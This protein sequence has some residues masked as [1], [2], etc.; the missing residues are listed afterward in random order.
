MQACNPLQQDII[1]M[2]TAFKFRIVEISIPQ[3]ATFE[4]DF[5]SNV[6]DV[7]FETNY[8]Y[9]IK[10]EDRLFIAILSISF[11][12]EKRIVVKIEVNVTFEL[13]KDTFDS[14]MYAD[15]FCMSAQQ[16]KILTSILYGS[17]RGVLAAKLENSSLKNIIL[18]LVDLDDVMTHPLEIFLA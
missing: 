13:D 4:S 15:K 8:S 12:Q 10:P 11:F 3:F 1:S 2:E 9:G 17:S 7:E 16:L 6:E 18:P 14:Y 5:N